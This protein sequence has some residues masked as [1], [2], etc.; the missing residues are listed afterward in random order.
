MFFKDPNIRSNSISHYQ[1]PTTRGVTFITVWTLS[2][3]SFTPSEVEAFFGTLRVQECWTYLLDL[4]AQ[5]GTVLLFH[6]LK[7]KTG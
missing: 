3:E 1:E 6:F 5:T 2:W 7:L 4:I